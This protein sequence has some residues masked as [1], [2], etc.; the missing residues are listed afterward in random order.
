MYLSSR[1]LTL[2]QQH[3]SRVKMLLNPG[4]SDGKHRFS[5]WVDLQKSTFLMTTDWLASRYART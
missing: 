2:L 1:A 4:R 5:R 3:G